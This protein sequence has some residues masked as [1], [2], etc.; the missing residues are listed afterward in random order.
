MHLFIY[1]EPTTMCNNEQG[2][3]NMY[4]RVIFHIYIF[5]IIYFYQHCV[6]V[7][8]KHLQVALMSSSFAIFH[9]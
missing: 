2:P 5:S 1:R 3:T 7:S 6:W 8:R 4:R 9:I